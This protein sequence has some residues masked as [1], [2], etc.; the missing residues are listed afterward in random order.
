MA[1]QNIISEGYLKYYDIKLRDW[2]SN[3]INDAKTTSITKN[4]TILISE[5]SNGKVTKDIEISDDYDILVSVPI[6]E[7]YISNYNEVAAS[8]IT[9][10]EHTGTNLTIKYLSRKP[11][12]DITL[13]VVAISK[14]K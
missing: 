13:Q 14:C 11:I 1:D 8:G 10:I 12:A 2:V 5:W 7:Q 9:V 3:S 4:F 6:G